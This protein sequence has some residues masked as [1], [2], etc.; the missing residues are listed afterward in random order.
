VVVICGVMVIVLAI[1]AKVG[2]FI[3]GRKRWIFK[4]DKN[5]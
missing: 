5:S 3:P 1:G 2:G 4:G